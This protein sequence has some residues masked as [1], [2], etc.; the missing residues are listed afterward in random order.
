MK[1]AIILSLVMVGFI[2]YQAG[3][4]Y[5]MWR[6][7]VKIEQERR[8]YEELKQQALI[9]EFQGLYLYDMPDGVLLEDRR[10]KD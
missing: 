8:A 4:D 2:A 10:L 5:A 6:E 3:H 9:A 7:S 1:I